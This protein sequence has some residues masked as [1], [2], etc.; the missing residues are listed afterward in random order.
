MS[1]AD[2]SDFGAAR[3][4]RCGL[5]QTPQI[6]ITHDLTR[7]P[8]TPQP[9]GAAFPGQSR[10]T[11]GS[12]V[13][14][15]LA[16]QPLRAFHLSFLFVWP[17]TSAGPGGERRAAPAGPDPEQCVTVSGRHPGARVGNRISRWR[18]PAEDGERLAIPRKGEP[19]CLRYTRSAPRRPVPRLASAPT[20][21]AL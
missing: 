9:A 6:C 4:D 5:M 18:A 15:R 13:R 3:K 10:Q 20:A 2:C 1:A 8:A 19:S 11:P 16:L 7:S 14:C 12:R 21:G 17:N